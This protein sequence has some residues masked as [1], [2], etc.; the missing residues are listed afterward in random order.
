MLK[1]A[2]KLTGTEKTAIFLISIGVENAAPI[3]KSLT[4]EELENVTVE[5]AKIKNLTSDLISSVLREYWELMLAQKFTTK[6]GLDFA[7]NML[8]KAFG[9]NR[10]NELIDKV[11][12]ATQISG[13][14]LLQSVNSNELLNYLQ[15]EHPQTIALILA[16]MSPQQGAEIISE[17]PSELQGDVAFRLATMGKTSPELLQDIEAALTAQMGATFGGVL[18]TSGGVNVVAEILNSAGRAV[19][20][21]I[22]EIIT[23]TDPELATEIK[24]LMFVFE[25][26]LRLK[27]ID[28]QKLLKGVNSKT[29]ATALK[30]S[31]DELKE[32]IFA[33]M[34]QQAGDALKEEIEYLGAIR[35]RE[36]EESQMAVVEHVRELEARG[37]I[38]LSQQ[39][40]EEYIE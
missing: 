23:Q 17:L 10:A 40:Q 1:P 33:N 19:E 9:A 26:L 24:N 8:E 12:L 18:S 6:G 37:D 29:L 5:I 4:D 11:K 34:S 27:D 2:I 39:A 32:K 15:K 20:T 31:S 16:N 21:N 3:L 13:F 38:V 7:Q 28:V 36:V 35:L 25:D 22:M 14:R 30:V